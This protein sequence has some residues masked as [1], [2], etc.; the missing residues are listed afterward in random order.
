MV[1]WPNKYVTSRAKCS[2][3]TLEDEK[4]EQ[5]VYR[6]ADYDHCKSVLKTPN[7]SYIYNF[8]E[9]QWKFKIQQA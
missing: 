5:A 3:T 6:D 9:V 1:Y 8:V 4:K 7:L 2:L